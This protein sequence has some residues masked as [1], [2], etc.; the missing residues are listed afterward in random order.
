MRLSKVYEVFYLLF[1]SCLQL[2]LDD[3]NVNDDEKDVRYVSWQTRKIYPDILTRIG[4]R[5]AWKLVY[6]QC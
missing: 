3:R 6:K 2:F 1:C 5:R 4:R